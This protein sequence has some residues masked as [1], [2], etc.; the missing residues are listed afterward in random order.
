[1]EPGPTSLTTVT[2]G[3]RGR[4]REQSCWPA[5][6]TNDLVKA[7]LM[8]LAL[9]G[10]S[11]NHASRLKRLADALPGVLRRR[12]RSKTTREPRR[13]SRSAGSYAVLHLRRLL[14]HSPDRRT[15]TAVG[16][17]DDPTAHRMAASRELKGA[18]GREWRTDQWDPELLDICGPRGADVG[19]SRSRPA[20]RILPDLDDVLHAVIN[21]SLSDVGRTADRPKPCRN[22]RSGR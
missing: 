22:T 19:G 15:T 5:K 12:L 20:A 13:T 1:V 10:G 8:P 17:A 14:V 21:G 6:T 4:I 7:K 16:R 3:A 11:S 18:A 2:P 9:R